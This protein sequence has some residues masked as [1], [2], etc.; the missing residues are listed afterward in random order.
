MELG[1]EAERKHLRRG[2]NENKK[3]EIEKEE[4]KWGSKRT[5]SA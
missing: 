5:F 1:K 4:Q 3:N 2:R